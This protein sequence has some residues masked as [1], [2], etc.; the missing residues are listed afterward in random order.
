MRFW[1]AI[2]ILMAGMVAG[3][4]ADPHDAAAKQKGHSHDLGLSEEVVPF[5]ELGKDIERPEMLTE[6]I[7][8]ALFP[9]NRERQ[10]IID[11]R[12]PG[13]LGEE[14]PARRSIFGDGDRFLRT[15]PTG[16]GFPLGTGATLRPYWVIHG[17]YRSALQFSDTS[18]GIDTIE[19]ANRL[20]LLAEYYLTTTERFHVGFRPLD[21][22]GVFSGYTFEGV[23]E[24]WNDGLDLEPEVLFFEGEFGEIFPELDKSD[25]FSLDYSFAVGRQP[26]FFQQGIM[27]NDILDGIGIARNNMFL[28]GSSASRVTFFWAPNQVHR[29]DNRRDDDANLFGLFTSHDFDKATIDFDLAYVDG[30]VG[31]GFHV[32]LG[33]IRRF[34]YWNSTLRLNSSSALDEES[35]A[36]G[37]GFL[38]SHELSR[39]MTYNDDIAYFNAFWGI[40]QFS[41]AARG[42]AAGGPLGGMGLLYQAVGLG[43]YGAP[44]G[45]RANETVGFA[46]GYQHFMDDADKQLILEVGGRGPT[47]DSGSDRSEFGLG[48]RY[49]AALN[50]HAIL[51][52]DGY[53][54]YDD[55]DETGVGA[56]V[57]LRIKF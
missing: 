1:A 46:L 48:L 32:G 4:A 45:N 22:E 47:G 29:N 5:E 54:T 30:T 2:A 38:L 15:G 11:A 27:V 8:N 3:F 26:V 53:G 51:V 42:P 41:S 50:Q 49:Q 16:E 17:Q 9:E 6:V 23:N 44:L 39:T 7:D 24:G 36:I 33:H 19:W 25:K 31:D 28:F 14:L 40:D 57:E 34:G 55:N 10:E 21:E 43:T 56:R 35:A 18:D 12:E 37:S 52:L 20:D 13:D